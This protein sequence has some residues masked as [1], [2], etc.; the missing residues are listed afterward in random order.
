M[1]VSPNGGT[2]DVLVRVKDGEEAHGPQLLP[3]G[4]HVLFTLA[5]GTAP[6]RWDKA[7]IVV[8]SLKSGERK[9]LIE[10]GSDARYRPDG[11]PRVRPQRKRVRGR[12]RRAA[13]GGDG[14]PRAD[15]RRRQASDVAF[16]WRGQLS[17]SPAPAPLIYVPGPISG[18]SSAL[19]DIALMD[20]KGRVEPLKLPP[21]AYAMPRVSPDGT[22]I[23]FGNDDDKEAI[24]WIYDLS[25]TSAMQRL[26]SG[27]NNRF[28]IW[29]SDSKRVAFQSDRDG[30]RAIFWQPADGGVAERLTTPEPGTSHAPES[31]SPKGD[32][33]LFS[34]TKGSDVSLWTF[35]LQDKKA[36][37]FG[38]VHSSNPT[39]AVFS[40][41]G[42]WVAYT[43]TERDTTTIYVQPFPATGPSISSSRKGRGLPKTSA[44]VSGRQGAFLRSEST[45][46]PRP[47][48][49]RRNRHLRSGRPWRCRSGFRMGTPS[50]ERTMTSHQVRQG[51]GSDHR[52]KGVPPRLRKSDPC[53]PEL[54]RGAQGASARSR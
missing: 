31:W 19:M 9:T 10:G 24:V 40:P 46:V 47:S 42:R 51:R 11:P 25:G 6:D 49:S 53:R 8:Q 27:G 18:I 36:T 48:A 34:V 12:V 35:S 29:T 5:T 37:P 39:G 44:L 30:D 1:R 28:P 15:C 50:R 14:R 20:R 52:G 43:S 33:F 2:P 22:R 16:V 23:A 41:D 4:Q 38:A 26:T 54:V 7:H 3:G 13:A 21:G 17:A 45:R 32:R